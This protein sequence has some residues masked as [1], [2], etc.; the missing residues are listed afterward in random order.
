MTNIPS[1]CLHA[2]FL[3]PVQNDANLS[4]TVRLLPALRLLFE[5]QIVLVPLGMQSTEIRL[6]N[7]R[8]S[9]PLSDCI[10][11]SSLNSG[12]TVK[13]GSADQTWRK[14][15]LLNCLFLCFPKHILVYCSEVVRDCLLSAGFHVV[16]CFK[17][18]QNPA[19]QAPVCYVLWLF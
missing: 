4:H 19:P 10:K 7:S 15:L 2:D 13:L 1:C 9:L 16:S 8:P 12:Q 11:S 3:T 18:N 14:I 17:M 6:R 5:W